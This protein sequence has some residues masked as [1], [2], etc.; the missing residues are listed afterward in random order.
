M[1]L[2]RFAAAP[3]G[4]DPGA[5]RPG[6]AGETGRSRSGQPDPQWDSRASEAVVSGPGSR[7]WFRPWDLRLSLLA[8][9]AQFQS[10]VCGGKRGRSGPGRGM[11][12]GE[13]LRIPPRPQHPSTAAQRISPGPGTSACPSWPPPPKKG[14]QKNAAF[15]SQAAAGMRGEIEMEGGW[16]P[17]LPVP[18]HCLVARPLWEGAD[19]L[20]LT[21]GPP[22][23]A[24]EVT[25]W[26]KK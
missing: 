16:T 23:V 12:P 1:G 11:P 21:C 14:C 20:S 4:A 3:A 25:G 8:A 6:G 22:K 24:W 19:A 26:P 7:P 15:W 2:P 18:R 17:P 5:G 10:S 13:R 9:A